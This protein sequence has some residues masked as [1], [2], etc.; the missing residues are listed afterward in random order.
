[1]NDFIK[2]TFLSEL[3]QIDILKESKTLISENLKYHLDN[4]INVSNSVFRYSSQSHLDLINEVRNLFEKDLIYLCKDDEEIIKTDAGKV[5]FFEGKMVFLDLPF[6]E[7]EE[8]TISE[9]KYKGK[10]VKLGKPSRG[11][12]KKFYVYVRDPKTKKIV[13]VSFGAKDG[14]RNLAV[15]L[16]DPKARKRFADRHNCES[17]NDKTTPGYWSCRLPRYAKMLG[18][19]GGGKWW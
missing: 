14:G 7:I 1:M 2:K 6:P 3:Y 16:K 11:G 10:K 13:K 5:D 19:S 9:A 4:K 8:E 18:L 15:K 17:K 12:S